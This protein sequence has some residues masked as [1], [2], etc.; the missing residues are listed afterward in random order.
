LA[1]NVIGIFSRSRRKRRKPDSMT[2]VPLVKPLYTLDELRW[3]IA[4][5]ELALAES[6]LK[7]NRPMP[8]GRL[9]RHR[10]ARGNSRVTTWR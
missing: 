10:L 7:N 2:T 5:T 3:K 1:I 6:F 8:I 4:A 9:R